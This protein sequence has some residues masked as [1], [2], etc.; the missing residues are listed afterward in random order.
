MGM[1]FEVAIV[2]FILTLFLGV[3]HDRTSIST[4]HFPTVVALVPLNE[5]SMSGRFCTLLCSGRRS[6]RN[7]EN[8]QSESIYET[9]DE[10]A[11]VCRMIH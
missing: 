7:S 6:G 9:H 3:K 2:V 10:G 11:V 1:V 5:V 8:T 4:W